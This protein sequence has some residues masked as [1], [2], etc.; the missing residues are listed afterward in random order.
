[1]EQWYL[2]CYKPGKDNIYKAQMALSKISTEVFCP[3]LRTR[4][5]RTDRPGRFRQVIEPLFPGYLFVLFDPEIIHTSRVEACPGINYLV[6]SA[7]QITPIRTIVVDQIMSLPLCRD[8]VSRTPQP[9]IKR[10]QQRIASQL[11][12][13]IENTQPE[14]RGALALAFIQSLG[15]TCDR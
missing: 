12:A 5:P 15:A 7:G 3:Q 14:E 10:Q 6:R 1:M 8:A 2:A 4:R 11:N 13:F 9:H